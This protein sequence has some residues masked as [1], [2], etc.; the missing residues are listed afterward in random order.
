M[1]SISRRVLCIL[2]FFLFFLHWVSSQDYLF[3]AQLLTTDDGLANLQTTSV[4]KDKQGFLWIGTTYGLNRYDGYS[5]KLFTKEKNGLGID[6]IHRIAADD[7]D[8]LWLFQFDET[9]KRVSAI[10]I[11]DPKTGRAIPFKDYFGSGTSFQVEQVK[12]TKIKDPKNRLWLTT[13]TGEI[14]LYRQGAFQKVFQQP[15]ADFTFVSIDGQDNIWLGWERQLVCV[16][17]SGAVL[18]ALTLSHKIQDAWCGEGGRLWLATLRE[19]KNERELF[20][21]SLPEKGKK[22]E[23]FDLGGGGGNSIVGDADTFCMFFYRTAKGVWYSNMDQNRQCS[24]QWNLFDEKGKWITNVFSIVEKGDIKSAEIVNWFED[25]NVFWGATPVG[26]LKTKI[27][28]NLFRVVRSPDK[29][30]ACRGIA[31]DP[32]GNIYF[33]KDRIYQWNPR[34]QQASKVFDSDGATHLLVFEDSIL[35]GGSFNEAFP[36]FQ[37]D[38]RTKELFLH[39]RRGENN[40]PFSALKTRIPCRF[41]VGLSKGMAILDVGQKKLL[42]FDKYHAG[43]LTDS[44][45]RNAV[46][47]HLHQNPAGIWAAT[48][49][50]VFLMKEEEGVVRHFSNATSDLPFDNIRHIHEDAAGVFWLASQG[51]GIIRWEP[52]LASGNSKSNSGKVS[53]RQFTTEDGLSC[54]YVYAIYENGQGSELWVSSDKGLMRIHKKTNLVK[55]YLK[56]HGLPHNEFNTTSH[57]QAKDG[58]LYFGGLGGL[59][60]FH[61]DSIVEEQVDRTPLA[62]TAY[63]LFEKNAREMSDKTHL[64]NEANKIVIQPG[65]KWFELQFALLDFDLPGNHRYAYRIEGFSDFW[66]YSNENYV[67]ITNL[68]YGN[69]RLRI[70][71]QN[72]N[73]DWSERELSLDIWVLKPFYLQ[74]WFI[75]LALVLV[76]GLVLSAVKWRIA[77]LEKVRERLE[78]EVKERTRQLEDNNEVITAQATALHEMDK[79]KTRFFSNITHEF[80][81]PLTLIIGPLEQLKQENLPL[82]FK[83]RLNG[84]LNNARH[85]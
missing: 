48:D 85:L 29:P 74:G 15:G 82:L 13:T 16:N 78:A 43:V 17:L 59:V 51:G 14:F 2:F 54:N 75:A 83:R 77:Y 69:Y 31:E 36:I 30:N 65:D 33:I 80:R 58:T 34:T 11:F 21:W 12:A 5:F 61:P 26:L 52:N 41:W 68:P 4:F 67:R 6:Y 32:A 53:Y 37:L 22:L 56:E 47:Y 38:L 19:E 72:S 20:F 62:F 66:Q 49:R 39:P 84:V 50:G 24:G 45:L 35:F 73:A 81:T 9:M 10:D 76:A 70:K 28:R 8:N 25:G 3:D 23:P 46:V 60:I 79:S 7:R 40:L 55:T 63:Y 44:L 1:E 57:Y 18:N 27:T 71:G 42:P 64:L